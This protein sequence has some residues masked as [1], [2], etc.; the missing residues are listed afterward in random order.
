M[1]GGGGLH[2]CGPNPCLAEYLEHTPPPRALDLSYKYSK[3]DLAK[4][5]QVCRKRALVYM[6]DLP[7]LPDEA[8]EAY[9]QIMEQMTPDVVVIPAVYVT[10]DDTPQEIYRRLHEIST[11]YAKRMD[12]GWE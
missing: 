6:A 7:D 2:N 4:I 8:I 11:E 1:Y 12:W 9:R 10:M 3:H 5:K